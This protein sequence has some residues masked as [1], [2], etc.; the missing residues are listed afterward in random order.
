[1]QRIYEFQTLS[2]NS[3]IFLNVIS[4]EQIDVRVVPGQKSDPYSL[5]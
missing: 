3:G 2:W 5:S 1:M 4:K